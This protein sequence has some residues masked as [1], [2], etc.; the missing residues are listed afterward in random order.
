MNFDGFGTAT[1]AARGYRKYNVAP[2][3]LG[4]VSYDFVWAP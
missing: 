3:H 4:G 1:R 2:N